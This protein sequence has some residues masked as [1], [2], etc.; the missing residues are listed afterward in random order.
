MVDDLPDFRSSCCVSV[1]RFYFVCEPGPVTMKGGDAG[2][3]TKS[4][5]V[6]LLLRLAPYADS[7]CPVQ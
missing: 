1:S 3:N 2:M 7:L 4:G 5:T 6:K